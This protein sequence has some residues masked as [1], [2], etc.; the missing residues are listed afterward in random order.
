MASFEEVEG[1]ASTALQMITCAL[2]H[3]RV[4]PILDPERPF[5]PY[6]SRLGARGLMTGSVPPSAADALRGWR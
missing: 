1:R 6:Y 3:L 2:Q 5:S 4:D